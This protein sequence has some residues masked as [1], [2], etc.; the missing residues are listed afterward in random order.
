M[1]LTIVRLIQVLETGDVIAFYN[2]VFVPAVKA[3]LMRINQ[4]R[5]GL[6]LPPAPEILQGASP[7]RSYSR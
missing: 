4:D 2:R 1:A 3:D 5:A 6:P 7:M